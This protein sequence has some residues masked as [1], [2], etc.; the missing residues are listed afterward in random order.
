MSLLLEINTGIQVNNE[1]EW[2]DGIKFVTDA[3]QKIM[4]E[5]SIVRV[6]KKGEQVK[7]LV[8]NMATHDVFSMENPYFKYI[9]VQNGY[10]L[11]TKLVITVGYNI[12]MRFN[13]KF[14]LDSIISKH[15]PGSTMKILYDDK[16]RNTDCYK[17]LKI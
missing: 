9:Q 5:P 8:G 10:V 15:I 13:D 2:N 3:I 12:Q 6:T 7:S 1:S 17:W 4:S 16:K 14:M 11:I